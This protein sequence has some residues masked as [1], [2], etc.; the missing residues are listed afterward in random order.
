M[1]WFCH[2]RQSRVIGLIDFTIFAKI[3]TRR[4]QCV[5]IVVVDP[6]LRLH[7]LCSQCCGF[8]YSA[9]HTAHWGGS[10]A[11]P[12]ERWT[13]NSEA[14]SSSPAL[15]ASWI[16]S[17]HGSPE[18]KSS[19]TLVDC[20]LVCLRPVGILNPVKF[21]LNFF[22]KTFSRPT[23]ISAINTAE[24]KRRRFFPFFFKLFIIW[25]NLL[26]PTCFSR[27]VT[28][29]F[30]HKMAFFPL[31]LVTRPFSYPTFFIGELFLTYRCL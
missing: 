3:T 23:S 1:E 12:L 24:G 19:T 29:S 20:Q 15:T 6:F 10:M 30:N 26:L 22:V 28:Y 4:F 14:P 25:N 13:C 11:E 31:S 7:Y 17:S 8:N 5:F 18:F 16:C 21:N 27:H 2:P 9:F